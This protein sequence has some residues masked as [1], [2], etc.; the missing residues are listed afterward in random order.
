MGA[1]VSFHKVKV[2]VEFR[3]LVEDRGGEIIPLPEDAFK[4]SGTTV[5][6]VI[7]VIPC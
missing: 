6:T 5:R 4:T 3:Q 7:V 1:G 2:A